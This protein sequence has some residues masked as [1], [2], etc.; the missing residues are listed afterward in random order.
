M[1]EE[2]LLDLGNPDA[3]AS[4]IKEQKPDVVINAAAFTQ[5]D[6]CE[7]ERDLAMRI[8]GEAVGWLSEACN[9]QN[10]LLVQISTDYVFDGRATRPYLVTDPTCPV[11]VYGESKLLGEA[12][13]QKAQQHLIIRTAWLYDAWGKNFYLTMLNAAAQGRSLKVVHDQVGGPTT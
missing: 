7:S 9:K 1:P 2:W 10:A 8:N 13:A 12:N 6:R 4:V 5:V 11:S 3:I